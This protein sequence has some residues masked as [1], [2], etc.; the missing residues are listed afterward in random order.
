MKY[1]ITPCTCNYMYILLKNLSNLPTIL[2][3]QC[4]CSGVMSQNIWGGEKFARERSDRDGEGVSTDGREFS[5]LKY[6]ICGYLRRKFSRIRHYSLNFV[7]SCPSVRNTW[8][9]SKDLRNVMNIY[10]RAERASQNFCVFCQ[11]HTIL[12][13]SLSVNHI[14]SSCYMSFCSLHSWWGLV[15]KTRNFKYF[16]N[17]QERA[18]MFALFHQKHTILINSLS[19][20]HISLYWMSFCSLY[21]H[22]MAL[23]RRPQ[24]W[25]V[26]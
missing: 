17:Y 18:E 1:P 23:F 22:D 21:T 3:E 15:Q 12:I 4:T 14:L 24:T 7:L 6:A 10:K 9:W 5:T 2:V 16:I 20:N 19:V 13:N 11:K 25:E 26:S 8:P